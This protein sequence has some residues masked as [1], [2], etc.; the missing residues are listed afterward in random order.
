V[1]FRVLL[2]ALVL[3]LGIHHAAP[4]MPGHASADASM[5]SGAECTDEP[6]LGIAAGIVALCMGAIGI[7]AAVPRLRRRLVALLAE[8]A[9]GTSPRALALTVRAGRGPP[10]VGPFPPQATVR[11]C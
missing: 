11:R 1:I 8:R 5:C 3:G 6:G 7:A 2:A 4:L 9:A 10:A